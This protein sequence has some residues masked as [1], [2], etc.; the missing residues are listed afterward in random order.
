MS[1]LERLQGESGDG[2]FGDAV[3]VP[4]WR[5]QR[6][7]EPV[8]RRPAAR[9]RPNRKSA[10]SST[11]SRPDTC[12]RRHPADRRPRLRRHRR[13]EVAAGRVDQRIGA[14]RNSAARIRSAKRSTWATR[15]PSIGIVSD[16]RRRSLDAPP[17]A[18]GLPAL[19]AVRAALHGRGRAHRSRRRR[20][21]V[22]GARP[23]SRRS[24]PTCRSATSRPWSRSSRSRPASRASD[25]S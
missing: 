6:A 15:S 18:G 13:P 10:P 19:H 9:S 2:A 21:G 22:G 25:R 14:S 7:G 24:I 16:A 12:A 8:G 3:P 23:P 1:V 4:V 20:G 17:R 11:R 5:R